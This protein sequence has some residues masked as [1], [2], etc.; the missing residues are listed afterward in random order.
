M[1]SGVGAFTGNVSDARA[2]V[3]LLE[4]ST[5]S[6]LP[7]ASFRSFALQ[8]A[9]VVPVVSPRLSQRLVAVCPYCAQALVLTFT[10]AELSTC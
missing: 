7:H 6:G 9:Q 5:P 10:Y 1:P 2:A 8:R 3:A 4:S